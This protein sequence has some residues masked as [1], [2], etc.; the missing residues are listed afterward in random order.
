MVPVVHFSSLE[1][2]PQASYYEGSQYISVGLSH[3]QLFYKLY[4][5][6]LS[7]NLIHLLCFALYQN[8]SIEIFFTEKSCQACCTKVEC[9]V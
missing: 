4:L 2:S 6:T 9:Q 8:C 1:P 3:Q 5:N 7:G